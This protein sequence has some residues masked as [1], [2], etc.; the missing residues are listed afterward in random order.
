MK[1]LDLAGQKFNRLLVVERVESKNGKS[2]FR[3]ICDCGEEHIAVGYDIKEGHTKSCGC[4]VYDK[5]PLDILGQTFGRLTVKSRDGTD[6]FGRSTWGCVC[7]CGEEVTVVG[8]RLTSGN[9]KSCGCLVSEGK[10][11]IKHGMSSGEERKWEYMMWYSAKDRAR[12]N[13]LDFNIRPEDID[14][15][16]RCPVLGIPLKRHGGSSQ[17]DS[18]SLDRIDPDKGYTPDN[19]CVISQKANMIK[20]HGSVDEVEKVAEWMRE[21]E[22]GGG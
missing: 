7:S 12:K 15:P 10:W 21:I 14:I 19:I 11:R 5:S 20:C 18:A 9:T 3:C 17:D 13:G 22:E 2:R 1:P 16:D 4:L 6:N 8:S